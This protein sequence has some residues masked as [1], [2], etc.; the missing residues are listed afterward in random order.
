LD[1]NLSRFFTTRGRVRR[2]T[3]RQ[4]DRH[5]FYSNYRASCG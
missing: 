3:D 2:R 5:Y 4:I 1:D